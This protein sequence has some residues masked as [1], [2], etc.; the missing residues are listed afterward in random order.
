M[1][2]EKDLHFKPLSQGLGFYRK[3]ISLKEETEQNPGFKEL[4]PPSLP[5][6]PDIL[7]KK[8]LDLN[9]ANTYQSLRQALEEPWQKAQPPK[10]I[11]PPASDVPPLPQGASAPPFP[12]SPPPA[13]QEVP[14][15]PPPPGAVSSTLTN[16]QEDFAPEALKTLPLGEAPF[17]HLKSL[18]AD[19]FLSAVLFFPPLLLF[20]SLSQTQALGVLWAFK[21]WILLCFLVFYQIYGLICR[22]FCFDTYGEALSHRRLYHKNQ[23]PHPG[24]LFGRFVIS[25]AT[26]GVGLPLLSLLVKKDLLAVL[27]RLQFQT[28][29]EDKSGAADLTSLSP[30][31]PPA[32]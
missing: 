18:L 9:D 2:E 31:G 19:T 29:S 28:P 10:A 27:S 32:L 7:L 30:Q 15:P 26:G 22:L 8:S 21:G 14:P 1:A 13:R 20:V 23:L 12:D 16:Q 25:C 24:L 17:F 3:Q 4:G 11:P 5:S 6:L